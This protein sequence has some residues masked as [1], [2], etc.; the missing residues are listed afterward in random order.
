MNIDSKNIE[1]I[2]SKN[3]LHLFGYDEY[4]NSFIR[5]F[6]KNK[7]PN[8]I[9]LSGLKGSGKATFA[10]HFINYLLSN[11]EEYEYSLNDFSIN[12]N[13]KSYKLLCNYTHP[14]FFL[15]E[16]EPLDE[17]IKID[18]ARNVIKFLSKSSYNSNIRIVLID[19]AEYLNLNSANSLLKII[20]E[21]NINTFFFIINNSNRKILDTIKS[22]CIEFKFFFTLPQ[23]KKILE[24]ITSTYENDF[25]IEN[26]DDNFYFDTPG[27]ILRYL[28]IFNNSKMKS[29]QD[30]ISCVSYLINQY[31]IKKDPELLTS[32]STLIELFYNELALR[33]K[34][35]L[36][37]YFYN[38]SKILNQINHAKIFNLDKKNLF[39]TI[40]D[41]LKN[42]S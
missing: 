35:N 32:I 11:N 7:L 28:M 36:N 22:R 20:E 25:N 23:K 16:N 12:P 38:R 13:N 34:K 6:K 10:Y 14:N 1:I 18:K 17:N 30:K 21:P 24:K 15:L 33:S 39:I 27:N 5:L 8:V 40:I 29:Y 3:Q 2:P 42:E 41:M 26:I 9:L 19:N 4:F 31:K 37:I